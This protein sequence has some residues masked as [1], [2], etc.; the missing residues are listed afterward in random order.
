MSK[1]LTTETLE[2]TLESLGTLLERFTTDVFSLVVCGGSSLIATGLASRA[3]KDLDIV[4]FYD[5]VKGI[6]HADPL[7]KELIEVARIVADEFGLERDWLNNGPSMMVND[8]MENMGL[9]EGFSDRLQRRQYGTRLTIYFI[10]RLDQIHFKVFAAA[11]KGGPSYHLD[12][13]L[14][15][16]PTEGE[17]ERAAK[18]SLTQDPSPVFFETLDAML[19]AIGHE[20]VAQKL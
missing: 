12:D 9:P 1:T 17:L 5:Q 15:L 11:D 19:R 16:A 7:P 6:Q 13:L 4:A 20:R 10:S 14:K 3:T 18:W 2:Q 8:K